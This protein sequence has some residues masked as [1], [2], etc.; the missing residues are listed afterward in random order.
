MT[1]GLKR[2]TVELFA[3]EAQWEEEAL[4]TIETLK[5]VLGDIAL[6]IQH[7]GST[8]VKSI[9]AKPII[10]IAVAVCDFDAV[11]KKQA[12]LETA[13]F[14]CRKHG[15][16]LPEQLLFA[17][18]SY[19]NGIGDIQTHFIHVVKENSAE[20]RD[21]VNFRDYLNANAAAA[22]EYEDLKLKLAKERPLDSG[23]E[24]Y[25]AGKRDFVSYTLRKALVWSYL[26]KQIHIEIDRP[27]GY[28][29]KKETY[30]LVYPINYGYIPGVKGGD[31]E[32]LDVYLLGANEPLK[33]A[34]C[35]VIGIAHRQ[36][37]VED[38]L[39][40]APEGMSFTKEEIEKAVLF[41]EQWYDTYI[42]T[43]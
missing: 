28:V 34:D 7:V 29:H 8:S 23:R 14:Y 39:I 26:G 4:R 9:K 11:L 21:Y 22:K 37:D 40:A 35:R 2:G 30:S 25:L 20:W 17:K 3:H 19:Y 6:D 13:G 43:V 10:D 12:E 41:Q 36:N 15:E 38:K 27:V 32:D 18:G 24:R 1:L 5:A 42:E 33:E 31:G 16:D